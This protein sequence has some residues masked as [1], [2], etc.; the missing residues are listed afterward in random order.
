MSAVHKF[1]L[2]IVRKKMHAQNTQAQRNCSDKLLKQRAHK[3]YFFL[4]TQQQKKLLE[5]KKVNY[6][7]SRV[8]SAGVM[9][10]APLVTSATVVVSSITFSAVASEGRSDRSSFSTSPITRPDRSKSGCHHPFPKK[11]KALLIILTLF[12]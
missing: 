6:Y 3:R 10:V 1:L 2:I 12:V 8:G 7:S 9:G 4:L 11:L 5:R